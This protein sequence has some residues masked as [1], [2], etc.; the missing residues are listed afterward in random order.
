MRVTINPG[1]ITGKVSM[2]PSKSHLHR[3]LIIAALADKETVIQATHTEAED[4]VA[5]IACLEALGAKVERLSDGGFQVKP[6]DCENLP[7]RAILPCK[8]SGSTLRFM[9]PVVCALGV[10]SEFHMEGRLPDRPINPLDRE[11]EQAGIVLTRPTREILCCEGKLKY[12]EF[13]LPGDISSQYITGLIMALPLLEGDS[14]LTVHEPIESED[15]INMTLE[16]LEIF[17]QSPKIVQNCYHI[18]GGNAFKSPTK[19]IA[20]GDWSNAAFWLSAGAMPGGSVCVN[21]LNPQSRQGD[22]MI[23]DILEQMGANMRWEEE[24][25]HITEGTRK[26]IEIDATA[27]PDLIPVLSAVAAVG[28]GTTVIKNAARLRLKESDRLTSTAETL[29]KLGANIIE[30]ADGLEIR[31][32]TKLKGGTVDAWGDHRIAMT[33]AIASAACEE[34]VTITGA[35]AVNKSYPQFWDELARLGKEIIMEA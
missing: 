7:H 3:L 22:K 8:E 12:G 10:T 20:E 33:A 19:A 31:G 25:I 24:I 34:P 17:E 4:I 15:Y 1:C 21:G 9:L 6:L 26:G 29:N 16:V 5:T 23:C 2:L 35:E 30:K 11:L 28:K 18:Q 27:I 32:V 14:S 13:N